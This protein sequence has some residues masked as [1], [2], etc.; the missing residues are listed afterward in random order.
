MASHGATLRYITRELTPQLYIRITTSTSL[1]GIP[2]IQRQPTPGATNLPYRALT[3][4]IAIRTRRIRAH[5]RQRIPHPA[6]PPILHARPGIATLL[7]LRQTGLNTH[8]IARQHAGQRAR[9]ARID[10]A[11]IVRVVPGRL[12]DRRV[13]VQLG[14]VGRLVHGE[15]VAGAAEGRLVA[16]AHHVAVG[17]LGGEGRGG[18]RVRAAVALGAVLDAEPGVLRAEGGADG[19]GHRGAVGS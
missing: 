7:R 15:P 1:P 10:H 8:A 6:L 9:I 4:H 19:G 11:V 2:L 18:G 16:G 14:R 5:A 3:S 12:H 13:V 17:L